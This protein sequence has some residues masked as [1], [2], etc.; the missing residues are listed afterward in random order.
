ME[1]RM[2]L[3]FLDIFNTCAR[4]GKAVS[5]EYKT[6]TSLDTPISKE[7][8]GLDSL[9]V[10]LTLSYLGE[11][12]GTPEDDE[13]DDWPLDTINTLK[14]HILKLKTVDP[15]DIYE[16]TDDIVRELK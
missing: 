7:E 16:T 13:G 11:L 10:M 2:K 14:E 6:A 4:L 9:D 3:T 1:A 12:Y 8:L 5:D 15:E